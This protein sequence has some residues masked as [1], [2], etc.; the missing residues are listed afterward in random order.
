[1]KLVSALLERF[2]WMMQFIK[3][4]LVGV[5]NL[6]VYYAIY[7]ILLRFGCHYAIANGIGFVISVLNSFLWNSLFV[8]KK[9]E[10]RKRNKAATLLKTFISYALTGLVLQTLLLHLLID[11]MHLSAYIAPVLT[12]CVTT[13]LNFLL[14]KFWS[15]KEFPGRE[16]PTL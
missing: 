14:N 1:V 10:G 4:G 11:R 5:S 2:P 13:P 8:F 3:F 12:V 15:F 6:L 9:A 16:A 7:S